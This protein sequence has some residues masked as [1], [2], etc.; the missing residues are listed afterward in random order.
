MLGGGVIIFFFGQHRFRSLIIFA[1]AFGALLIW[2]STIKP[3]LHD[4]W[5]AD[6]ARQ[7]TGELG[8]DTLTLT[9]VRNFDWRSDADFTEHWT[10]RTYDLAKLRSLDLFMSYWAGPEM[11][12]VIMSFGFEDG[13]YLAWSVEVR[14]TKGGEFSPIA[15]LF[16]SNP[17]VII[18]AEERDVVGVRSNV[19][20]ED[21]QIYR[22][23]TAPE[24]ARPI[25]MEYVHDANALSSTPKFY[26]SIVTNCTTAVVK[27]IAAAGDKIPFDWRLIVNGYLPEYAY[28]LGALD[29]RLS[30]TELRT[31]AHIDKRANK[32]GLAADYSRIIRVGVPFPHDK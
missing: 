5:A 13:R 4:D 21:V 18:A 27:M 19:R 22:L 31:L 28:S 3:A 16:K 15:D 25:L 1:A 14:R 9:N 20:G 29:N 24:V 10:T 23:R 8:G 17:L 2:W 11:A 12:H 6:V 30:L 32:A 7:V 26:N